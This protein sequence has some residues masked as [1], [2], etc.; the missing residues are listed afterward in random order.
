MCTSSTHHQ[1]NGPHEKNEDAAVLARLRRTTAAAA[2]NGNGNGG[3]ARAAAA[4]APPFTITAALAGCGL[5]STE[6]GSGN[7]KR[8]GRGADAVAAVS[9][10]GLE[11]ADGDAADDEAAAPLV[12]HMAAVLDGHGG[13]GTAKWAARR[14]PHLVADYL[15]ANPQAELSSG[16][17][18]SRRVERCCC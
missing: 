7:P 9:V 4:A 18:G 5:K 10:S 12:A 14:L 15:R 3:R 17:Y 2:A 13:R 16:E 6:V 1:A 8:G 11:G